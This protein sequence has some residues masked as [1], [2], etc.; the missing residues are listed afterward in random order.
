MNTGKVKWFNNSR[1]YGFIELEGGKDVFVHHSAIIT[2][3][4]KILEEG[5]K[6]LLEVENGPKGEHAVKVEVVFPPN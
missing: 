2:K 1:G 6:V 3:G 4:Y 5:Q